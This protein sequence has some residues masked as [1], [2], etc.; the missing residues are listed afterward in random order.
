MVTAGTDSDSQAGTMS[1][2]LK[3]VRVGQVGTYHTGVDQ[4]PNLC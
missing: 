4:R 1:R 3:R 2:T